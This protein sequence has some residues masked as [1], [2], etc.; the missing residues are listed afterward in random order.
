MKDFAV[1]IPKSQLLV[2][3]E[4]SFEITIIKVKISVTLCSIPSETGTITSLIIH[5]LMFIINFMVLIP[6]KSMQFVP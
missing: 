6:I 5:M 1:C 2:N 4:T 3:I